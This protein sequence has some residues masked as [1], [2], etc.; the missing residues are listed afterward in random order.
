M[1]LH[2]KMGKGLFYLPTYPFI[3]IATCLLLS[4]YLPTYTSTHPP[5]H[6]LLTCLP[7]HP[8]PYPFIHLPILLF[9]FLTFW[10]L[11]LHLFTIPHNK[12]MRISQHLSLPLILPGLSEFAT[13]S[14]TSLPCFLPQPPDSPKFLHSIFSMEIKLPLL[15]PKPSLHHVVKSH[16]TVSVESQC[17]QR[18]ASA[19]A[20][21]KQ[22]VGEVAACDLGVAFRGGIL[23]RRGSLSSET[24][25]LADSIS[26]LKL[27]ELG[28]ICSDLKL[29]VHHAVFPLCPAVWG[30]VFVF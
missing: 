5:V 2:I 27:K 28:G 26:G 19:F 25:P 21:T 17:H 7:V 15:Y 24:S 18:A 4:N 22:V 29:I 20:P 11:H 13:V 1:K 6:L 3:P 10:E 16:S 12:K 23:Q 9:A 14:S 30:V 8:L